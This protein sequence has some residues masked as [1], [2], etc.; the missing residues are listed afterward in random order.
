[1]AAAAVAAVVVD[2]MPSRRKPAARARARKP[3]CGPAGASRSAVRS[4]TT[5][6]AERV[7][8]P[9]VAGGTAAAA[10]F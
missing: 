7:P 8:P 3:S 10:R 9:A 1:V 4:T 5:S 2:G 6:A